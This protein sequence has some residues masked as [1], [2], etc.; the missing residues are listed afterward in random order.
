VSRGQLALRVPGAEVA[1]IEALLELAGAEAVALADAADSPVLEPP[2]GETPLWPEVVV[3]A[4]FPATID[5]D[6][7]AAVLA[8]SLPGTPIESRSIDEEAWRAAAA[9]TVPPRRFGQR[10]WLLPDDSQETPP[11]GAVVR[12]RMGFAFGTGEHPTTAL[13]LEWLDANPP[14]GDE[15]LDYGSG[16]GVLA[17]AALALGAKRA[18][19][20]DNDPQACTASAAN[21]ALNDARDRMQVFAP[22][23][24]PEHLEVDLV[25]A[26][27]LAGP[28]LGLRA[29]FASRLR[30][31]G[32]IVLSGVLE[33][34]CDELLEA[35]GAQ[36]DAFEVETRDGWARIAARRRV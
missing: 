36:F 22:D 6:A 21:A 1:R 18:W 14:R 11:P 17:L 28:L 16:S 19:A 31:G 4:L 25:L 35:Y 33:A 8:E 27:I 10:L 5:V 20:V 29:Y 12:R 13:C 9:R 23:A 3:T 7:L 32:R 15:V 26:N 30:P 24:L 2:P 34:Q